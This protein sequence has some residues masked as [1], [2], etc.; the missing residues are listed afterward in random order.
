[1]LEY[2]VVNNPLSFEGSLE[3]FPYKSVRQAALPMARGVSF[4]T[5]RS[6]VTDLGLVCGSPQRAFSRTIVMGPWEFKELPLDTDITP[7]TVQIEHILLFPF[8]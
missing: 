4:Q 6:K 7:A 1:M 5:H 2:C 3:L 8:S